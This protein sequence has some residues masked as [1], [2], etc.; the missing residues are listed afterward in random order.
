[1]KPNVG[2]ILPL[3]KDIFEVVDEEL[4]AKLKKDEYTGSIIPFLEYFKTSTINPQDRSKLVEW[5]GELR[6]ILF[7]YYN[8]KI[9]QVIK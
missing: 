6:E 2:K 8:M 1:M 4:R 5:T 7:D 9:K 3:Y